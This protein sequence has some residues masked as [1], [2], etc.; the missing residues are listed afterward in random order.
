MALQWPWHRWG[1]SRSHFGFRPPIPSA[2]SLACRADPLVRSPR[3]LTIP[4]FPISCAHPGAPRNVSD[5][6][7]CGD[8][9]LVLRVIGRCRVSDPQKWFHFCWKRSGVWR[10]DGGLRR[11][12]RYRRRLPYCAGP[13]RFHGHAHSQRYWRVVGGGYRLWAN[14]GPKAMRF[15][16]LSTGRWPLSLWAAACWVVWPVHALPAFCP[17][18]R[19]R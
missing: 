7:S 15:Q 3:A 2:S 19:A 16:V 10:S 5:A 8:R 11:I 17:L 9:T 12:L 4:E 18:A 1:S 14:G 6:F 13:R